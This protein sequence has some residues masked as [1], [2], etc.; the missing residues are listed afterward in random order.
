MVDIK[1][2]SENF[3]QLRRSLKNTSKIEL[4]PN[5]Q[6]KIP[7]VLPPEE[8][9]RS[10]YIRSKPDVI[11]GKLQ[12]NLFE[13]ESQEHMDETRINIIQNQIKEVSKYLPLFG[14]VI[15]YNVLSSLYDYDYEEE[16]ESEEE[17]DYES[18]IEDN[19]DKSRYIEYYDEDELFHH[20]NDENN[21]EW[22]KV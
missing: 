4:R 22:K 2:L 16:T 8:V 11:L 3:K 15:S 5:T 21:D 9:E 20:S 12:M 6:F 17:T 7:K 1:K 13:L 19:I 18:E 14:S 10:A